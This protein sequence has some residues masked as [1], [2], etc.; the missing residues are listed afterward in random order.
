MNTIV[1][2]SFSA[3]GHELAGRIA[4]EYS[5]AIQIQDY[6]TKRLREQVGEWFKQNNLLIFVGAV[7]IAVR[8][9]TPF[10]EEKDRD[11]AVL[12]VDELGQF[13]IPILSGHLGGANAYGETLAEVISATPVI[14]TATD[15]NHVFAVDVWAKK[16]QLFIQNVDRIKCISSA[17]LAG[18]KVGVVSDYPIHNLPDFIEETYKRDRKIGILISETYK[19]VFEQTLWMT[20]K[21]YV[22]G[23][24]CR[25]GIDSQLFERQL[26]ELLEKNQIPLHL[27]SAVASID[28]KSKE[29]AILHFTKKF[30][31]EFLTYSAEELKNIEGEFSKSEFVESITGVDNVCERSAIVASGAKELTIQKTII[32][33]MTM[34]VCVKCCCTIEW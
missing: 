30:G 23:I 31:I 22:L 8:G 9:I 15:I 34:A 24:G 33:A 19:S 12:V 29:E 7:G 28:L 27:V 1:I 17:M 21:K 13:V 10:V 20:P 26:L 25:K 11:P 6:K 5:G 2:F 14:T 16:Q 18:E 32:N 4:R 3:K